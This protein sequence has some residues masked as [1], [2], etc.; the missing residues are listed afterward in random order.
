MAE[1]NAPIVAEGGGETVAF[2]GVA[3]NERLVADLVNL[4]G[5]RPRV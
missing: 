4:P 1:A 3:A 2:L 5:P